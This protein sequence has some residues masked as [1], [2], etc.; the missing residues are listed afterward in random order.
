MRDC[1]IIVLKVEEAN[2]FAEASEEFE[3]SCLEGVQVSLLSLKEFL[4]SP[5]SWPTVWDLQLESL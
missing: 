1:N 2:N 3:G 4:F 5:I